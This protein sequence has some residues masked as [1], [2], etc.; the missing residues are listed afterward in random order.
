MSAWGPQEWG[1]VVVGILA[2]GGLIYNAGRQHQ[3]LDTHQSEIE[4]LKVRAD[5]NDREGPIWVKPIVEAIHK[6]EEQME[7][8]RG[9][10]RRKLP[11]TD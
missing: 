1:A 5:L 10:A 9:P 7:R 8:L 3:K 6:L 4:K 11:E 2:V